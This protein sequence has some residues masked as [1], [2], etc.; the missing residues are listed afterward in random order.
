MQ[1]HEFYARTRELGGFDDNARAKAVVAAT[2]STLAERLPAE[3]A[4][5]LAAQLPEEIAAFFAQAP[6]M[7]EVNKM[8]AEAFFSTI[9]ERLNVNPEEGRRVAETVTRVL[10]EAISAGELRH[11]WQM[12]P[13]DLRPLLEA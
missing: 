12:M 5:D 6:P 2:L 3:E 13:G 1:T 9:G 11:V 4:K 8:H 7:G 10:R